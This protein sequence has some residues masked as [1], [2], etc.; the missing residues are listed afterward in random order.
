MMP[1]RTEYLITQYAS[2]TSVLRQL[3]APKSANLRLLLE[4]LI[5]Q[6]LDDDAVISSCLRSNAKHFRDPFQIIDM[7]E[8]H[9][10]E[11]AR[12]AFNAD[13]ETE[14]AIGVWNRAWDAQIPPGKILMRAGPSGDY[15]VR[16]VEV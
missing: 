13:P 7:H 2:D 1:K 3:R 6:D 10:S 4:R 14:D 15:F 11:Q 12:D 16:E 5:C 8:S 9:R